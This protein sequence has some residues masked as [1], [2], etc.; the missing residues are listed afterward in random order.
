MTGIADLLCK[1]TSMSSDCQASPKN[2]EALEQ[3][4]DYLRREPLELPKDVRRQGWRCVKGGDESRQPL[5]RLAA[6]ILDQGSTLEEFASLLCKIVSLE[7]FALAL[8]SAYKYIYIYTHPSV[9]NILSF[10]IPRA[11]GSDDR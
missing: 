7:L 2:W 10:S 11:H 6:E 5:S 8:H 9:E 1:S 3:S 4:L